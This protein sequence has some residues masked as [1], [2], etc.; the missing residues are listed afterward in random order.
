MKTAEMHTLENNPNV[1]D[2]SISNHPAFYPRFCPVF[3]QLLSRFFE[4][5]AFKT[6]IK[7]TPQS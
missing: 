6:P 2:F 7:K 5:L 1:T 4:E 3:I